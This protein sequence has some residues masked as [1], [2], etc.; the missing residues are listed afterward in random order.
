MLNL[1]L[2]ESIPATHVAPSHGYQAQAQRPPQDLAS[3]HSPLEL[4]CDVLVFLPVCYS[5]VCS[6][7]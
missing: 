5:Q 1:L 6:L 7:K 4:S 2:F 3:I